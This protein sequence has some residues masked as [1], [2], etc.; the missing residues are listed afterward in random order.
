LRKNKEKIKQIKNLKSCNCQL[1][2]QVTGSGTWWQSPRWTE[3][4]TSLW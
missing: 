1:Y 4:K 3:S 2:Y